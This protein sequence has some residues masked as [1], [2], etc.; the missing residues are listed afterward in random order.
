MATAALFGAAWATA[1][2]FGLAAPTSIGLRRNLRVETAFRTHPLR[3]SPAGA[4]AKPGAS[5]SPKKIETIVYGSWAVTCQYPGAAGK[6]R[7]LASMRVLGPRRRV[8]LNWQ[9]GHNQ[10]GRYVAA[11]YM[12]SGLAI[13]KN[14]AMVG[15]AILVD[16]GAE[17]QFSSGAPRALRF[18]SCGPQRCM[19]EAPID[20]LFEKEA[21]ASSTATITVNVVGG[22]IPFKLS[23]KGID[24][25]I[26][27][28]RK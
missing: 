12:P 7:C 28:T 13:K 8:L 21:R 4:P 2:A 19:A 14:N 1:S 27:S 20:A 22:S 5:A 3:P 10:E 18:I 25:A 24:K 23:I 9:I 11:I 6:K 16:K 15:G 17:L 26:D